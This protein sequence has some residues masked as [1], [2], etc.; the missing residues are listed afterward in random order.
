VV[1]AVAVIRPPITTVANGRCTSAPD[2]DEIAI[3]KNPNEAT[4]A[5]IST[6]LNLTRVPTE[7]FRKYH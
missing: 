4:A 2:E 5:V 7:P 3:G 6:G 1:K